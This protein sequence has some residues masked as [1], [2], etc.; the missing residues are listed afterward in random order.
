MSL[1]SV[2]T[3][4]FIVLGIPTINQDSSEL[5][6]NV[7]FLLSLSLAGFTGISYYINSMEKKEYEQAVKEL[8][9]RKNGR[10]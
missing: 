5:T 8:K 3:A 9:R 4:G 7:T 2:A 1:C 6:K 10:I